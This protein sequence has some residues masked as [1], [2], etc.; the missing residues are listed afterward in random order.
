M[1]FVDSLLI[2]F[3]IT[4]GMFYIIDSPQSIMLTLIVLFLFTTITLVLLYFQL[5]RL[6]M[7]TA[8][9]NK[10][11]MRYGEN[12][13]L[14]IVTGVVVVVLDKGITLVFQNIP[15]IPFLCYPEIISF[16]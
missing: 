6:S 14:G 11:A 9:K 15:P 16:R 3:L 5:R 12:I 4:L 7:F 2:Y 13:I 8:Q 10:N 1:V